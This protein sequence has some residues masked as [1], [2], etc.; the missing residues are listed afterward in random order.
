MLVVRQPL[1]TGT[2]NVDHVQVGVGAI[3]SGECQPPAVRRPDGARHPLQTRIDAGGGAPAPDVEEVQNVPPL[4]HG[5]EG[6]VSPVGREAALR[7]Q[8]AQFLEVRIERALHQPADPAAGLRV[9]EPE[10]DEHLAPGK[11]AVRQ[12]GDPLAI[13]GERRRE[14]DL[15]TASPVG[16]QLRGET[17][18]P[19]EAGDSGQ[20]GVLELL[21]PFLGEIFGA[22]AG[23]AAHRA[24]DADVWQRA[25][26]AADRLIAVLGA[27]ERH[28]RVSETVRVEAVGS[29]RHLLDRREVPVHRCVAH[30][31]VQVR[32][33]GADRE[34]L[35]G[36]LHEPEWRLNLRQRLESRSRLAAGEQVVLEGVHEL[37]HQH[38]LETRVVAGEGEQHAVAQRLRHT[39]GA[40]AQVPGHVVLA[41]ITA[42]REQDDRL[43]FAELVS[44]QP[45][46]PA[47]CPLGHARG[48]TRRFLDLGIVVDHEVLGLDHVPFEAVVRDVILA[49]VLRLRR[50]GGCECRQRQ[51]GAQQ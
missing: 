38:L 28:E 23:L 44:E 36:P 43:L 40:F 1:Q 2:V 6:E 51:S 15:T 34:V 33:I 16:Q 39:G 49:E 32:V 21:P 14:E 5:G 46:Q 13:R 45:G 17:T 41:E 47:I 12:K 4:T 25:E 9:G 37:V 50:G 7:V 18:W 35:R 22:P 42:R 31:R 10:I 8:D 29:E 30:H 48:I 27:D 20:I 24:V 3:L 11:A 19:L 26:N